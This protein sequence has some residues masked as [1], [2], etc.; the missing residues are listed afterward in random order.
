MSGGRPE[1]TIDGRV[2]DSGGGRRR[3]P[4]PVVTPRRHARG[5]RFRRVPQPRTTSSS[6]PPTSTAPERLSPPRPLLGI[7]RVPCGRIRLEPVGREPRKESRQPRHHP[8]AGRRESGAREFRLG[9][10]LRYLR[11]YGGLPACGGAPALASLPQLAER[12]TTVREAMIPRH[13]RRFAVSRSSKSPPDA[14][15]W[16]TTASH[17]AE[18]TI[19]DAGPV[20]RSTGGQSAPRAAVPAS[21][22]PRRSPGP[23]SRTLSLGRNARVVP[24]SP[25]PRDRR[26]RR[27]PRRSP[28]SH[29]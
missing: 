2:S 4:T 28:G 16:P 26:P 8:G 20:L 11:K 24:A 1:T 17:A 7:R 5:D 27:T 12:P 22:F 19:P 9:R 13:P 25:A 21:G 6:P 3:R 10:D 18:S 15:G 14:D 23:A 29:P